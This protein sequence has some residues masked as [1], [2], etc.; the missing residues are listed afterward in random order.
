MIAIIGDATKLLSNVYDSDS[1]FLSQHEVLELSEEE[2]THPTP[3][4][5][6]HQ[7]KKRKYIS[8]SDQQV[9]TE[10]LE[11]EKEVLQQKLINLK[12]METLIDLK[13]A[14]L[15]KTP[16]VYLPSDNLLFGDSPADRGS[17]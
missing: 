13:I 12:K 3:V 8:S 5:S 11:I 6:Y 14:K 17:N 10:K 15:T 1:R 7:V 4:A 9:F 2:R 16:D